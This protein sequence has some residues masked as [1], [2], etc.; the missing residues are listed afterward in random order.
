LGISY[1]ASTSTDIGGNAADQAVD[2][3]FD[4]DFYSNSP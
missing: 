2:T 1:R 3:L 4:N